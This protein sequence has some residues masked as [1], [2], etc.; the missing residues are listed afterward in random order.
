MTQCS[1]RNKNRSALVLLL[2]VLAA[3]CAAIPDE[4]V[5]PLDYPFP[6][7]LRYDGG[8]AIVLFVD[9][10]NLDVFNEMLAAG[11]L[12]NVKK[13]FV[14]RGVHV[15]R[16][17]STFPSVTTPNCVAMTTGCFQGHTNVPQIR[18]FDRTEMLYR[19]YITIAEKDKVDNDY[20]VPN[21]FERLSSG[22]SVSILLPIHRG[23]TRWIENWTSAGPP[24]FFRLYNLVDRISMIRWSI[25]SDIARQTGAFPR[26]VWMHLIAPTC[27][28]VIDGIDEGP[29]RDAI[30]HA[31]AQIGRLL[32]GLQPQGVLDHVTLFFVCD[33]GQTP[34]NPS[35]GLDVEDVLEDELDLHAARLHKLYSGKPLETRLAYYNQYF[36]VFA[37]A[38]ERSGHI[39]LRKPGPESSWLERPTIA[40]LRAYPTEGGPHD[41]IKHFAMKPGVDVAIAHQGNRTLLVSEKGEAEIV[42]DGDQRRYTV[43][44]G[45]DPLGYST[46]PATRDLVGRFVPRQAWYEASLDTD[47]PDAVVQLPILFESRRTGDVVLSMKPGYNLGRHYKAGH[48]SLRRT[49]MLMPMLISG[50]GVRHGEIDHVRLVDLI[51]TILDAIGQKQSTGAPM[52]GRSFWDKIRVETPVTEK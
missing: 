51:P 7:D 12:P 19:D 47:Y 40:Q 25:I 44:S 2:C 13:F 1:T 30:R 14:D 35:E 10:I 34:T 37:C 43:L 29:Y 50:K 46:H 32:N 17:V 11:E 31:D 16:A 8:A 9:G 23:A 21:A 41:V 39:Y 49:D 4:R 20:A 6:K 3:G 36:A 33:H 27:T 48:G 42:A 38:G 15:R 26:L 28:A 52:D 5:K 45:D 24:Y 22:W 18:W